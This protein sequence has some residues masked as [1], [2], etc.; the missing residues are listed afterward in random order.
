[1]ILNYATKAAGQV[2]DTANQTCSAL[3]RYPENI[4]QLTSIREFQNT[5]PE[6]VR[7]LICTGGG[8]MAL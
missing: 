4:E 3:G 6:K 2:T 8:T 1:M 5:V 7:A